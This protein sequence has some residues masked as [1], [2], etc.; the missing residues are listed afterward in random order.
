M[1][2]AQFGACLTLVSL[3][4]NPPCSDLSLLAFFVSFDQGPQPVQCSLPLLPASVT[5][6]HNAPDIP[7][8]KASNGATANCPVP[9]LQHPPIFFAVPRRWLDL[10]RP[11]RDI[12]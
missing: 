9:F 8:A 5:A 11:L 12:E 4:S 7:D 1:R 6:A 10:M 3:L 2:T